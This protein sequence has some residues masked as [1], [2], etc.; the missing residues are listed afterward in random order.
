MRHLIHEGRQPVT[1]VDGAW[2]GAR[3]CGFVGHAPG[4][5]LAQIRKDA[6]KKSARD[7]RNLDAV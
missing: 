1:S 2:C 7:E 4:A 3:G 5:P 6:A